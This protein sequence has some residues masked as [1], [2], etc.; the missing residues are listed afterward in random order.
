MLDYEAEAETVDKSSRR[1]ADLQI[2][3]DRASNRQMCLKILLNSLYGAAANQYFRY[4]NLDIAEGIT[5]SGQL[6]IHTAENAVNEY[7]VKALGDE[8]PKD[9]IIASDTDS[10]TGD[11]LIVVNDKQVKIQD[12]FN[13]TTGDYLRYD[14]FNNDYV[15]DL[16][17]ANDTTLSVSST[18][19]LQEKKIKYIMKHK[20]KKRLFKIIDDKNNEV[21]I[22]EDHSIIVKDKNTKKIFSVKPSELDSSKHCILR[23]AEK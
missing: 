21:T 15:K 23:V 19:E 8:K 20:V 1:Y 2:E 3:I 18:G 7:L 22:T 10:V 4:F 5:L 9:R 13:N 6:A 11:T 16:S 14:D 12:Y 17:H